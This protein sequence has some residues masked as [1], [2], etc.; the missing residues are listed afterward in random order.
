LIPALNNEINWNRGESKKTKDDV[1]YKFKNG[2]SIDILAA[3]ESSRG[4]RRTGRRN[5]N[6]LST[7][8]TVFINYD[9][10]IFIY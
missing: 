1:Q 10:Y 7:L 2:S 8:R 3:R 6:F 5:I 4:Q 9:V